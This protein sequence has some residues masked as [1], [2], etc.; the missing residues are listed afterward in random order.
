MKKIVYHEVI[1]STA[2]KLQVTKCWVNK[3]VGGTKLLYI[4]IEKNYKSGCEKE[5]NK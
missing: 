1:H 2:E 3:S 5:N 4:A